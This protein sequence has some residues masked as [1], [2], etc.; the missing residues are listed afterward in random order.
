MPETFLHGVEVVEIDDGPRTINTVRS[1]VIGIIGTAPNAQQEVKASLSTGVVSANNALTCTSKRT[2]ILGNDTG[3]FLKDPKAASSALAVTVDNGII[4]VSLATN[5]SGVITST[6]AQVKAAV[7][8]QVTANALVTLA[9]TGGSTGASAVTADPR[10]KYLSGGIDEA[11]PLNTPVLIAGSRGDAAKLDTVGTALGTLPN[12]IDLILDQAPAVIVVVRVA[13]ANNS[14]TDPG[15][16]TNVI[17]GVDGSTGQYKGVQAFLSSESELG[18][19][20]RI[21]LAPG[22]TSQRASAANPVVAELLGVANR[23]RAVIIADGPG[24]TDAAAVQ[25]RS[26]WGSKRI[27]I[28]DPP[29]Q[30][31]RN[32]DFAF[33]P[34]SSVVAGLMALSDNERGF[35][36][37]PSNQVMAGVTGTKRGIDFVL[38]DSTCR[39]NLLNEQEIATV[40]RRDGYRLWGN[41]TASADPKWA[42]LSVVRTADMINESILQGHFWAVDRNITK[43]YIEDVEA[44]VNAYLDRLRAQGAILGGE[45]HANKDLNTPANIADG[46][47]FFDVRFTPPFPAEHITFRSILTND[48]IE[49]ALQ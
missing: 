19:T 31:F 34:A 40:I 44:S 49:E 7:E 2:G 1:G 18:I 6:G 46:K 10:P 22:F 43:T 42:F 3:V 28:A 32:G 21:L 17:G 41:R 16:T 45:C 14:D 39:A 5:S 33:E 30:V 27:Y 23:L 12:A 9:H 26:D 37:S 47:V 25:Y 24:T 20:P 38:G 13:Q 11:F 15:T 35:W 4:T 8:A 48:Y 36:W 29:I